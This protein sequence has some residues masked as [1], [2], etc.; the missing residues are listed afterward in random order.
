MR[1]RR[2]V[3]STLSALLAIIMSIGAIQH[4]RAEEYGASIGIWFAVAGLVITEFL[5]QR[6]HAILDE[7]KRKS[8]P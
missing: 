1:L 5:D 8:Q 4:W 3:G 2:F 6:L 7:I